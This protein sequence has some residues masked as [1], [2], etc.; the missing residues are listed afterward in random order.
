[1]NVR[2]KAIS[3]LVEP[4]TQSKTPEEISIIKKSANISEDVYEHI[5]SIIKPGMSELDIAIEIDYQA[6]LRGSEGVAFSTIVTCGE[7]GA[8]VHGQPSNKKIKKNDIVLMDF[9]AKVNGFCSDITRTFCVGKPKLEH[10]NIYNLVYNAMS[11]AINE[12]RPG[13]HG[14]FLD[15][16]ARKSIRD[17]GFGDNFKHSL[18]HGVGLECH[19]KPTITFRLK[20]QI[21]PENVILAIEPGVYFPG[22]FGIRVEDM[23]IVTKNKNIK[24][25]DAPDK[26]I[27]V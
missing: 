22:K 26:L 18:G 14:H 25:T 21:I 12:A 19:E 8:I 3:S 23:V 27:S 7:R 9:G 4:Y 17:A 5:L 11:S 10:K 15:E 6:R 13:M 2:I 20:N 1:M 24:L 16:V